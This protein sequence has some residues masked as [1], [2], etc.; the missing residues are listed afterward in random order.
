M[1]RVIR[2][3]HIGLA[4]ANVSETL[5]VFSGG[6]GLEVAGSEQVESDAV[7]VTFLP[8]GESRLEVLEPVGDE[9]PLQKFLANRGPGIHHICLE[10]EDLPGM[11]ARLRDQGVE[12][13][14][15]EPRPGA[16]G[17]LVAFIHPKSANGVLIE[18]VESSSLSALGG[19]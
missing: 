2:V 10:V 15:N 19:C 5:A 8:V 12:L 14:D 13:V 1:S 9:G 4:T 11:L 6:M 17:S 18:L 3:S 16:H 7:R